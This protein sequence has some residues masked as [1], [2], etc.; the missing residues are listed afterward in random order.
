M[1]LT[2]FMFSVLRFGLNQ[3]QQ[4]LVLNNSTKQHLEST[5]KAVFQN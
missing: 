3:T 1:Q 2:D 4:I 5:A